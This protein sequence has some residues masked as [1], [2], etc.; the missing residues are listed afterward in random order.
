MFVYQSEKRTFWAFL[1]GEMSEIRIQAKLK[2]K[3]DEIIT[4]L[5]DKLAAIKL[6]ENKIDN[7]I[8]ELQKQKEV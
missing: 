4:G 2:K 1:C 3:R 6:D 7:F 5:E 8:G